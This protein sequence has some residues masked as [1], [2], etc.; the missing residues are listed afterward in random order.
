MLFSAISS[1]SNQIG[2]LIEFNKN[3][4]E[5]SEKPTIQGFVKAVIYIGLILGDV[6]PFKNCQ[7]LA[8]NDTNYSLENTGFPLY[9]TVLPLLRHLLH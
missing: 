3:S 1:S 8:G 5:F 4:D 6:S 9:C 2:T 7:T